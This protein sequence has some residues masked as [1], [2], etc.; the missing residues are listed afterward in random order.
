MEQI[1]P[2]TWDHKDLMYDEVL[3]C[4]VTQSFYFSTVKDIGFWKSAR[5]GK[6]TEIV[7]GYDSRT[8]EEKTYLK[9]PLIV[10][11]REFKEKGLAAI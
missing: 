1:I 6:D 4:W 5:I 7:Q 3:L 2:V 11:Q 9:Y 8:H 10:K